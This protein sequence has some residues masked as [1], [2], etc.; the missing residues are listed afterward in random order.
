MPAAQCS[1]CT[2]LSARPSFVVRGR[3]FDP[4]SGTWQPE[5]AIGQDPAG[6][7]RSSDPVALL[8]GSGNALVAFVNGIERTTAVGSNYYARSSGSWGLGVG[9]PGSL[10]SVCPSSVFGGLDHRMEL[11][12]STDGNFLLAWNAVDISGTSIEN[13]F[14]A[15]IRIAHFTSRTGRGVRRRRWCRA[16]SSRTSGSSALAA[17]PPATRISLWTENDGMRTALKAMRLD[18]PAPPVR[19]RR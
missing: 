18:L 17:M 3:F 16:T 14:S 11:T 4:V 5:A 2:V 12:A 8:D 6:I 9:V 19:R 1:P 7:V 13:S 10:V 15:D